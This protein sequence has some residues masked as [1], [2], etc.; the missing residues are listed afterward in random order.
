MTENEAKQIII[1]WANKQ[2]GTKEGANNWNTYADSSDMTKLY[3]WN[4]QNQPWC[5]VFVDAGFIQCFGYEIGSAMTYQYAGC[6]GAACQSSADY[7]KKNKAWYQQ[8]QL[9]DQVFFIVGGG[10]GHTG[11]VTNVSDTGITTVE[12]N[13]SDMVARRSYTIGSPQIAGYGR[14]NWSIAGRDIIVNPQDSGNV[15]KEPEKQQENA[16]KEFQYHNYQYSVKLPLIIEGDYGPLVKNVQVL[17]NA[18]GCD[19]GEAD[20][21]FGNHTRIA[22]MVF[23]RKYGLVVD[24][25]VGGQTYRAL[26]MK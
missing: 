20:G 10:I 16:K 19:C 12:G 8:P 22:V 21:V 23:Q 17:L 6:S 24:G 11:I 15:E 9:G 18:H 7:Y 25:E 13:S 26:L 14:P 3:G 1:D 2:I 5:D 4:V